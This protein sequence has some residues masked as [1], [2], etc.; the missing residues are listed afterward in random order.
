VTT[1]GGVG[2]VSTG[3]GTTTGARTVSV[4]VAAS[5]TPLI[6]A[7]KTKAPTLSARKAKTDGVTSGTVSPATNSVTCCPAGIGVPFVVTADTVT[8]TL[9]PRTTEAG[10]SA[11][12]DSVGDTMVS[13]TTTGGTS[14]WCVRPPTRRCRRCTA[15]A[16]SPSRCRA[17]TL[18]V[19]HHVADAR[20][21]DGLRAGDGREDTRRQEESKDLH[22]WL[23]VL[24]I[25]KLLTESD[26]PLV[27]TA[28]S[29]TRSGVNVIAV[30][31]DTP[32]VLLMLI[33]TVVP[34]R[35]MT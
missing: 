3:G 9:S 14:A 6:C 31:L 28:L 29:S 13:G 15:R 16:A 2:C 23:S 11:N 10:A 33:V 30:V 35:A 27:N 24:L 7:E 34:V 12:V 26:W 25:V 20:G 1:G 32:A 21:A 17:G 22:G 8:R 19:F 5:V 18:P 4:C